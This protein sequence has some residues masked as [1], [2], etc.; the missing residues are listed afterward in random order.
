MMFKLRSLFGTFKVGS[1]G[2]VVKGGDSCS[3]GH[4][5]DSQKR[6]LNG[7]CFTCCKNCIFVGK[8]RK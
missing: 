5:F 7:H 3:K 2:L 8:D 6:I 1:P 4:G